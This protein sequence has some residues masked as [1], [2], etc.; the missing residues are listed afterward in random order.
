M[1]GWKQ[2]RRV[3]RDDSGLGPNM[4]GCLLLQALVKLSGANE[5]V[6]QRSVHLRISS[7]KSVQFARA[8]QGDAH[9][10]R[11]ESNSLTFP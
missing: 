10:I 5:I 2:R 7:L 1:E 6:L 8:R 11:P 4:Q 3:K 9:T